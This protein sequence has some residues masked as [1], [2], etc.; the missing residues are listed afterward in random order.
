MI[1]DF[2]ITLFL[3]FLNGFFVAAEF[4]IVKVRASQIEIMIKAGSKTAEVTKKMLGK[5]DS[6]LSATQLGITIA[7]LGLGYY[8]KNLEHYIVQLFEV[9]GFQTNGGLISYFPVIFA[10][11]IITVLHIV[12]GELAPKSLAIQKPEA[13]TLAVTYPLRWFYRLFKPF[14]WALNSFA[15]WILKLLGVVP[16]HGEGVHSPEEIRYLVEQGKESGTMESYNYDIIKNAFDFSERTAK[17]V[18]VPRT[19]MVALNA[20][21]ENEQLIERIVEEG[22]S[23]MPLYRDSLDNIIGVVFVKDILVLLRKQASVDVKSLIRPVHFVP[24][25]QKITRLLR[26][27]QRDRIHMAVVVDE[28][29]GTEGIITMEDIMEELVGE[30]QDEYDNEIPIVEKIN[31]DAYRVLASAPITD[32]NEYLPHPLTAS[33]DYES[34]SGMLTFNLGR[35]PDANERVVLENYEFTVL[36]RTRNNVT[37]VQIRDLITEGLD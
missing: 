2:L 31:E 6:Y 24:Q 36:K 33:K 13:V 10:F 20:N 18:M 29:G 12:F 25:N 22:F 27:F 17:Q 34:L 1:L 28:Y 11:I 4:A 23:R 37:L 3:V 26:Q 21:L 9:L 7:S 15:N 30:I 5:L 14:I 8:G 19:R 35:I 16:V 32:V